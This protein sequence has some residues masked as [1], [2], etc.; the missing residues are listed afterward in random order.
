MLKT[1]PITKNK[2]VQH[3]IFIDKRPDRYYN[4]NE[5]ERNESD[6]RDRKECPVLIP[7]KIKYSKENDV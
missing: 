7:A 6:M 3:K 5:F 1:I 2:G 4:V